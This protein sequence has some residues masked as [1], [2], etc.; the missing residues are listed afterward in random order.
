MIPAG[1]IIEAE[2]VATHLG[3][4][5]GRAFTFLVECRRPD[6]STQHAGAIYLARLDEQEYPRARAEGFQRVVDILWALRVDEWE[7]LPGTRC[8]IDADH[9]CLYRIGHLAEERW[10]TIQAKLSF[11]SEV[12]GRMWSGRLVPTD[13]NYVPVA[14]SRAS[15]ADDSVW[16]DRLRTYRYDA[17]AGGGW[18]A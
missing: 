10:A 5:H 14:A 3:F 4:L 13:E 12:F 9:G 1:R 6:G 7:R 17:G 8:R 18:S 11:P 16:R 15:P 2:I